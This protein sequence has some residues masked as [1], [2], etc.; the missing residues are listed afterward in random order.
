M[1][2][3]NQL[4]L[5]RK[6]W[7]VLLLLGFIMVIPFYIFAQEKKVDF[8]VISAKSKITRVEISDTTIANKIEAYIADTQKKDTTFL[9]L[10]YIKCVVSSEP[11]ICM[12]LSI[13]MDA[14]S[15]KDT[16][17]PNYYTRLRDK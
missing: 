10:G 13:D 2:K 14:F 5:P 11:N 4:F 8:L 17:L 15:S 9:L 1:L 16:I 7:K 6:F 3:L 12:E